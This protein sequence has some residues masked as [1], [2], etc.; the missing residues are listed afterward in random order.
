MIL[1]DRLSFALF[2]LSVIATVIFTYAFPSHNITIAL[3]GAAFSIVT[4]FRLI[5]ISH[6][7]HPAPK[8][9]TAHKTP[10][11]LPLVILQ[12]LDQ[13][14][15]HQ[16]GKSNQALI[17]TISN[18]DIMILFIGFIAF[19]G[20]M[21]WQSHAPANITLI[22]QFHHQQQQWIQGLDYTGYQL[23]KIFH[24]SLLYGIVGL[25][26][27]CAFSYGNKR[28]LI[29]A[30][31]SLLSPI[32]ALV[33]FILIISTNYHAPVI[34]WPV[35]SETHGHGF[36]TFEI[37]SLLQPDFFQQSGTG[38]IARFADG[39]SIA[40]YGFYLMF[41]PTMIRLFWRLITKKQ[42]VTIIPMIMISTG[43]YIDYTV[44]ISPI[45]F[46]FWLIYF[47]VFSLFLSKAL[48]KNK[49]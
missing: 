22:D 27:F 44:L 25:A 13:T 29:N 20:W 3:S 41:L 39:G 10:T 37:L 6:I 12:A 43:I 48:I 34:T 2:I 26:F 47:T 9:E 1:L 11:S 15:K 38:L 49:K 5:S 8:K 42:W 23:Y 24:Y 36:G 40:A 4:A 35:L 32:T 30:A 46:P 16:H 21:I 19:I 17:K 18:I 7:F 28:T 33:T 14:K 31:L 45:L